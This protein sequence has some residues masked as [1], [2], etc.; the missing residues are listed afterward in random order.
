MHEYYN[1]IKTKE[2]M[3]ITGFKFL[4]LFLFV[5]WENFTLFSK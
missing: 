5:M 1:Q 4:L 3:I 2:T